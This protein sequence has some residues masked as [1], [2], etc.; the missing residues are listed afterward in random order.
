[1]YIAFSIVE[2]LYLYAAIISSEVMRTYNLSVL[3][4][5]SLHIYTVNNLLFYGCAFAIVIVFSEK[6]RGKKDTL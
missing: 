3:T 1:M 6:Q 2:P 4:L 5:D